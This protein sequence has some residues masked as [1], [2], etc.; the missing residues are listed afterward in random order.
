LGIWGRGVAGRG[1]CGICVLRLGEGAL[2]EGW[3]GG[4]A[5]GIGV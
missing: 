5:C 1:G 2:G 3:E 4:R